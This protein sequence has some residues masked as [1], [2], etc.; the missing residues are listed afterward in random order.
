MKVLAF[1]NS[2]KRYRDLAEEKFKKGDH[3]GAL[4]LLFTA[5]KRQNDIEVLAD[6]ADI[7][8]D[9]GL[10]E[11]SNQYWF[12]YL[13]KATGNKKSLAYK[14]LAINFFYMDNFLVS[15]YYINLKIKLDG[16]IGPDSFPE[17]IL[18]FF[19]S[20]GKEDLIKKGYRIVY[21]V[22]KTDYSPLI[23]ESKRLIAH[24]MFDKVEE[25][26]SPIPPESEYYKTALDNLAVCKLVEG[27]IERAKKL[28]KEMLDRFG[29]NVSALCNLSSLYNEQDDKEKSKYYFERARKVK[30][31]DIDEI[32]K[33]AVCAL[34]QDMPSLGADYLKTVLTDRNCDINTR[35]LYA[36]ALLNAGKFALAEENLITVLRLDPT[37]KVALYYKRLAECLKENGKDASKYLP[38]NYDGDVPDSEKKAR[39]D[40]IKELMTLSSKQAGEKLKSQKVKEAVTWGMEK[41]DEKI[42]KMCVYIYANVD[43]PF[44]IKYLL[45]KLMDTGFEPGLKRMIVYLLIL[46]GYDKKMGVVTDYFYIS[47]KPKK[48][49]FSDNSDANGLFISSYALAISKMVFVTPEGFDKIAYSANKLYNK[50]KDL[51]NITENIKEEELSALMVHGARILLSD[52]T[53]ILLDLFKVSNE[54][55]KK[56]NHLIYG[57][58]DD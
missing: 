55:W 5:L 24:G 21:P 12:L 37:D 31:E 43:R 14:E 13:D 39:K 36:L 35:F 15:G 40:I 3:A 20:E 10:Y 4:S 17:E 30:T 25:V 18:E 45:S 47:L 51:P 50:I 41:G 1:D 22:D 16:V 8:A 2:I 46:N 9:M 32:F 6:I 49:L 34:E 28:N 27:E 38:I 56:I 58:S 48:F 11:M 23:R 7:Y 54:R 33:L 53:E 42:A 29:D 44:T 52:K 26:L 19:S 57:G